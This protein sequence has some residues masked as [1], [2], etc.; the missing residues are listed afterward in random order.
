MEEPSAA[1]K[2]AAD[3]LLASISTGGGT[4]DM[5]RLDERKLKLFKELLELWRSKR[6]SAPPDGAAV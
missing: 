1:P 4:Y 5:H 2:A 6:V 3:S